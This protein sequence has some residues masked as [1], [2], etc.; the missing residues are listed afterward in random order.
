VRLVDDRVG[1]DAKTLGMG[2]RH[3]DETCPV[4]RER[5]GVA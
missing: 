3:E 5:Q 2:C 1:A 4:W